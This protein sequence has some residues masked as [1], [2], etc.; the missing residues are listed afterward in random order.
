M[1]WQVRITIIYD[2]CGR[3]DEMRMREETPPQ[4]QEDNN[5]KSALG[6]TI[7]GVF[8]WFLLIYGTKMKNK[9]QP[10]RATFFKEIFKLKD[11]LVG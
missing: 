7:Q 3:E 8:L 10:T 9:F 4:K 11:L 5:R 1:G 2:S 6:A